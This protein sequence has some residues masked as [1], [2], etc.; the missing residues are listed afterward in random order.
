MPLK[1]NKGRMKIKS[2][3]DKERRLETF[4]GWR[5]GG[6]EGRMRRREKEKTKSDTFLASCKPSFLPF[7]SILFILKIRPSYRVICYRK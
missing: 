2:R 5:E 7:I 1:E 3:L 6:E 4:E